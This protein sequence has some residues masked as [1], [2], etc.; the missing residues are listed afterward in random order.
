MKRY[1]YRTL[2]F[3][4]PHGGHDPTPPTHLFLA[5][6]N[7]LG[8]EGRRILDRGGNAAGVWLL[9]REVEG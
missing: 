1:E 5:E 7:R 6:A 8:A 4:A 9:E 3:Q 2:S